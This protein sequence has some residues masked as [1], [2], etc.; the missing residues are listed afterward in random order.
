MHA[1]TAVCG[2]LWWRGAGAE[3][4]ISREGSL[5]VRRDSSISTSAPGTFPTSLLEAAARAAAAAQ[6]AAAAASAASTSATAT[7]AA[8]SSAGHGV[9]A[10]DA[11]GSSVVESEGGVSVASVITEESMQAALESAEP[12]DEEV[13]LRVAASSMDVI[14]GRSAALE[15]AV[16]MHRS[17]GVLDQL[18]ATRGA[19]QTAAA[20]P[21][22]AEE[23]AVAPTPAPAQ[24]GR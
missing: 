6:D 22:A 13:E 3:G 12:E 5:L 8:A 1:H 18:D 16:G 4:F 9:A 7:S 17:G 11:L 21:A 19:A 14:G 23:A 24:T 20:V 10:K 2:V 15:E